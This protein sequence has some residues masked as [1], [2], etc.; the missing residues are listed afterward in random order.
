MTATVEIVAG[1]ARTGKTANLLSLYREN[2]RIAQQTGRLGSTLWLAPTRRSQRQV[3]T[4]LMNAGL[5]DTGP[6]V[7]FAPNVFT[8]EAFAEQILRVSDQD[9]VPLSDVARRTL[10]RKIIDE[11]AKQG[12]L[13]YFAPIAGTSGFLDLVIAFISELKRHEIWPE[14]FTDACKARSEVQKDRELA[15]IYGRYQK[16]L[17]ELGVY[18]PDGRFWSART[19]FAANNKGPFSELTFVVI[20]GFTDFTHTQYEIL[21]ELACRCERMTI[22]LPLEPDGS[23]SDLFA[24]T[25]AA[26]E[27]IAKWPVQERAAEFHIV[28]CSRRSRSDDSL[29]ALDHLADTLFGNP[30]DLKRQADAGGIEIVPAA[31]QFAEI[32]ML[33]ERVK[34]LLLDGVPPGDII[35][36]FRSLHEYADLV[37]EVFAAS[38]LPFWRAAA[39]TLSRAP[40]LRTLFSVLQ[41]EEDDWP[42]ERLMSVLDSNH[43][44]PEWQQIDVPVAR[45]RLAALLRRTKLHENRGVMLRTLERIAKLESAENDASADKTD[46][47][48]H[49]GSDL[50]DD[51]KVAAPLVEHLSQATSALRHKHDLTGWVAVLLSIAGELGIRPIDDTAAELSDKDS[52]DESELATWQLFERVLGD[53]V[54]ADEMAGGTSPFGL[55]E[56]VSRLRDL[57]ETQRV[58]AESDEAGRVLVLEAAEIRNVDAPYLFLAGLSESSFP[59]HLNDDCLYTERERRRLNDQGLTLADRS[60]RGQDEMLLFYSVVTRARKQLALS[61][62]AVN[63]NGQPL[64]ASPYVAAIKDLFAPEALEVT[65]DWQLDPLPPVGRVLTTADLRRRATIEVRQKQPGLFGAMACSKSTAP[66]ALNVLACVEMA[67]ERFGTRGFTP[68]EGMLESRQN[69]DRLGERFPADHQFSATH[70]ERYAGCP[71]RSFVSDIL[72]VAPLEPPQ[73]ETNYLRR[74][75]L[76]HNVLAQLHRELTEMPPVDV[77]KLT[78]LFCDLA[79]RELDRRVAGT[80]LQKSLNRIEERLL[81]EWGGFYAAQLHA[82]L[83]DFGQAWDAAPE[84]AFLELPFG[85]APEESADASDAERLTCLSLGSG[86]RATYIQGRIDRIDVGTQGENHVLN[87]ID[88]KSGSPRRFDVDDVATGKSLQ[89]A[90][91][92]L[93]VR[94]LNI[95]GADAGLF[96][97]GYW[98]LSETGF[99]Q[100]LKGRSKKGAP[101][102]AAVIEVL[103]TILDDLV[104]RLAERMRSGQFPVASQDDD[105]TSRC[106]YSTVCRVNQVRSLADTLNKHW[107]ARAAVS[108]R[109][110]QVGDD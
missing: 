63:S 5:S 80:D 88:Y 77:G 29:P 25:S 86:D 90:L 89:L 1:V 15:C 2:L 71:F 52:T 41:L 64:F 73:V 3:L 97:M 26:L 104:P 75:T 59:H 55:G 19:A 42:F 103:D 16:Q 33:A 21:E 39:L 24:K 35:V 98:N 22:A 44:R 68:F 78:E 11:L 37:D 108:T 40:I 20:D 36:G 84:P 100:G 43:F 70:L 96:Q 99:V 85:S 66:V 93:A 6:T 8:F 28:K 49:A 38:G 83:N 60:S 34:K 50:Q 14:H 82:Y 105:C 76:L 94:R 31:G 12:Q 57:L 58:P 106:A 62:P 47:P 54:R 81:H 87:V 107:N 46:G 27:R 4:D 69:I 65:N 72:R 74:G 91:Y 30:R 51:A 18:D 32:E 7:S 67:V 48:R 9:V 10:L 17:L 56:F 45:R 79:S 53:A 102:D 13:P 109:P 92:A 23:R 110:N 101:I 95:T 61:Y